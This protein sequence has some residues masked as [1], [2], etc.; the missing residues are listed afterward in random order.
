MNAGTDARKAMA[1]G[2]TP[3][4][5]APGFIFLFLLVLPHLLPN[6]FYVHIVVMMAIYTILGGAW[7]II[8]GYAGQLSL[9]HAAFFG[10]G[11]YVSTLLVNHYG[12]SPWITLWLGGISALLLSLPVGVICFRL[13]GPYFTIA[14]IGLAEA[15]RL[16][17]LHFRGIT[18]G[19]QGLTVPFKGNAPWL[20]QFDSKLPYYY[21]ALAMAIGVLLITRRMERSRLG[22]YLVAI[23]QNQ[24]AAEALGIDSTRT[25]A[26]ALML[27][28]FLMGVG[29]VFY[30]QYTY[31]IDPDG[32]FGLG[33]SVQVAL[34]A[35]VG[36]VGTILGPALGAVILEFFIQ[37]TQILF[38]GQFPGLELMV[39]GALLVAVILWR[40]RGVFPW[41]AR[42]YQGALALLPT[43]GRVRT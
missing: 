36:G 3:E 2:L 11:A 8:S 32:A 41:F 30:A 23:G 13:Q 14:T 22:H 4:R 19:A 28:A 6:P 9:G 26:Q 27:S 16:L 20:L 31:V 43:F 12:V 10:T 33:L 37:S 7:N 38:A 39:Y 24:D 15:L 25:K 5:Y 21:I 35:I 17:V 1:G 40:P 34:V 18:N 42:L 29:G